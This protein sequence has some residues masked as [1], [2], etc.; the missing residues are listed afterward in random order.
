VET[1]AQAWTQAPRVRVLPDRLVLVARGPGGPVTALGAPIRSPLYVGPDPSAPEE[2]TLR[3]DGADLVV[4]DELLWLT[5]FE[6]AVAWGMAFDVKLTPEQA[7]QGFDRILVAGVRMSATPQAGQALVEE[8]LTDHARSRSGFALVPQG[9][10]TNNTEGG[11]SGFTRADDPDAS[12]EALRTDP[13]PGADGRRLADALGIDAALL[14][15]VPNAGRTDMAEARALQTA[16]WPATLGYFLETMMHPVFADAT[17]GEIRRFMLDHVSGRGPFPAIRIGAQP[18][19]V[20]ATTAFSRIGWIDRRGNAFLGNLLGLLRTAGADWR[21]LAAGVAHVGSAEDPHAALLELL[22]LHPASVEFDLRYGRSHAHLH[23]HA[24][25]VGGARDLRD[26]V[27]DPDFDAGARDLLERLGYGGERPDLLERWFHRGQSTLLGD[28]IDDRPLSESAGI[29]AWTQDG[30]NYLEWLRDAARASLDALRLQDGFADDRPP[31]ALLYLLAR[32]ALM[33]GYADA[34]YDLHRAAGV[35]TG[36]ELEAMKRE[37]AFVHVADGRG[38]ESRWAPLYAIDSRVTDSETQTVAEYVTATIGEAEPTAGLSEQLEALGLLTDLPTA[39]LERLLAEHL[40]C[41]A[42]RLDA[43][44]LGVA[45]LQLSEM[46]A[47]RRE[48][49]RGVYVGAYGWLEDIRRKDAQPQA[50]TLPEDLAA[51]FDRDGDPPL[52]RDPTNGGHLHAPSL[53]HAVTAAVLRSGYLANA[54]PENPTSLGVNLSSER[55]RLALSVLDGI[56]AGHGLGELLGYRLERGLHDRHDLAEVDSFI[57]VLRKAFPLRADHL[58]STRTPDDV[59]I[60]AIEARNVVDGLQL[61]EQVRQAGTTAYP[62]GLALP[63]ATPEQRAA[64]DAEV[65]RLLDVHDAVADLALAESV[66]QA[67][68]GNYDRVAGALAAYTTGGFPPEPDV[69]RTPATGAVL[70]HRVGLHLDRTATAPP[71]ATPRAVAEPP[72]NAWLESVLPELDAIACTVA[73]KHPVTGAAAEQRVTM[74]DLGLQP[75]DLL[76]L[77]GSDT[78]QAMTELDDRVLAWVLGAGVVAR[79]DTALEIRYTDRPATGVSVFEVAP[80]VRHLRGLL[81]RARPLRAS[82][83]ALGAEATPERDARLFARRDRIAAVRDALATLADDI[84]DRVAAAQGLSDA[85]VLGGIDALVDDAAALLARAAAF[86]IPETGWGYALAWRQGAYA[87]L[88]G[89]LRDRIARWDGRLV[90][91]RG[92]IDEYDALDLATSDQERLVLLRR[93]ESFVSTQPIASPITPAALRSALPGVRDALVAR[94][95]ALRGVADG[96]AASLSDLLDDVRPLATTDA[97]DPEPF[98]FPEHEA[99]VPAYADE[100]VASLVKTSAEV[101]RRVQTADAAFAAHDAAPEGPARVDALTQAAQAMLGD[102]FRIVPELEPSPEQAE[103]WRLAVA[104]SESGELTRFLRDEADVDLPVDEWLYGAARVR[105]QL[106]A[107]EAIVVLAGGF[108]RPE[109]ELVPLQLPYAPADSWLALRF[110]GDYVIDGDRLLYSAHYARPFAAGERQCALLLDEWTEVI[111]GEEATTGVAL[112]YDRPNAEAPQS[113]LLV[114]PAAWDGAWHW[115]DLV[116]ALDET[117]DLAKARAVEPAHVDTTP[118]ARF[119]PTTVMAATLRG[120]TIGTTLAV[121]NHALG[122]IA[123]G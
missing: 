117:L 104:A 84:G 50:V 120:M 55:V 101:T 33:L 34:A 37:P 92:L 39:R 20:L 41:A 8:L 90:T 35:L 98:A 1:Q 28:V 69:V 109:P 5:D 46:R 111:P 14:D 42:Y 53:N 19:G 76:A 107:W 3:P 45:N 51:I 17:V 88:V 65:D 32:H 56:R 64:I 47:G 9:T 57:F 18:Y 12:F 110:P 106:R 40:D 48:P 96:S 30:R 16:V 60:A 66:H 24:S 26:A 44:M 72:L 70:T 118:Y 38:S 52:T 21:A 85:D 23:N 78:D 59:S 93:A 91:Y 49:R 122:A 102:D 11:G 67:V 121:N 123:D 29:R 25:L 68:Q 95:D 6:R 13:P 62:F 71:G 82:D 114:T 77:V 108:E 79:P 87:A 103:E 31:G 80:L 113:L 7:A 43:W 89:A 10:P 54:G 73:W 2:E 115:D 116:G 105:E 58:A 100:L 86:G 112:N 81:L 94:Q 75:Y 36:G 61:I 74:A 97:F 63:A 99:R 15:H 4:P 27:S 119:L 83:V 22:G